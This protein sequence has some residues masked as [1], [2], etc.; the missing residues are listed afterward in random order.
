MLGDIYIVGRFLGFRGRK[1]TQRLPKVAQV[2][3][4]V[5]LNITL[6]SLDV[7][8]CAVRTTASERDRS[9][10]LSVENATVS[11][12]AWLPD[13][14]IFAALPRGMD[15]S[16][17]K[18]GEGGVKHLIKVLLAVSRIGKLSIQ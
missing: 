4:L 6:C 9:D 1:A 10:T 2:P 8:I 17:A 16:N 7:D 11:F 5:A 13:L 15:K 12:A 18:L 3:F 14:T